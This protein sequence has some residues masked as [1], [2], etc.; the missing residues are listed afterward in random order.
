MVQT[1]WEVAQGRSRLHQHQRQC[2]SA[3][4][5]RAIAHIDHAHESWEMLKTESDFWGQEVKSLVPGAVLAADERPVE[6]SVC[7]TRRDSHAW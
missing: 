7:P 1:W 4:E 3:L 6:A 5:V 2:G